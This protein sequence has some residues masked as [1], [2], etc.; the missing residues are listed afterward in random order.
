MNIN[1]IVQSNTARNYLGLNANTASAGNVKAAGATGLQKAEQRIQSQVDV[2]T[3]QLSSFGQLKSSVASA[4]TAAH[5]LISLPATSTTTTV[6]T[7]ANSFLTAFNTA[8]TT[9]KTTASVPGET[10]AAQSANRVARDFSR[11]VSDS[12]AT[13][14]SLKKIGFSLQSNGTLKLDATKFDAAQKADPANVRATL[15]KM[16]QQLDKTA[17]QEL[18]TAGNVSTSMN[19]LNQ[20]AA[21]LQ[22]Q[23]DGLTALQN[24]TTTNSTAMYGSFGAATYQSY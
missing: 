7:A 17:T 5:S 1:D 14:D 23:K 20:R 13:I 4:Q 19:A 8:M 22:T 24:S 11:T 6:K 3:A 2:T 16:G 9:A 15:A 18:A 12:T 21:V 10:A